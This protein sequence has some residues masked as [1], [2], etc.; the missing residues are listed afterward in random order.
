MY[1]NAELDIFES[2]LQPGMTVVDVGANVGLYS[3]LA[4]RRVS[5][6][7]RVFAFEPDPDSCGFLRKAALN[8]FANVVV[9]QAAVADKPGRLTLFRNPD[10]RGDDGV[11]F[12]FAPIAET[13][14]LYYCSAH[15]APYWRAVAPSPLL[16]PLPLVPVYSPCTLESRSKLG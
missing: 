13:S 6:S 12:D 1:E 15:T 8:G 4:A 16:L 14:R 2:L 7:D 3:A 11:L 5:S 9:E 10:N